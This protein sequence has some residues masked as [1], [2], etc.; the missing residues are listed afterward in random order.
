MLRS[1]VD[2]G[3]VSGEDL[4]LARTLLAALSA[5]EPPE[6]RLARVRKLAADGKLSP[7]ELAR[8]RADFPDETIAVPVEPE[9]ALG[10][11]M[12]EADP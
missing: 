1:L 2:G 12:A 5:E 6:E 10:P 3:T 9:T 8:A 7:V 11:G 4:E